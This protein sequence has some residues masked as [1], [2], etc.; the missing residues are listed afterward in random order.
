MSVISSSKSPKDQDDSFY[1]S[2]KDTVEQPTFRIQ[3]TSES[4]SNVDVFEQTIVMILEIFFSLN[5]CLYLLNFI[6]YNI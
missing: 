5:L 2:V 4:E 3:I 6:L 1:Y